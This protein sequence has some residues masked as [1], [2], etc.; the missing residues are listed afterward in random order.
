M[1]DI[2]GDRQVCKK[3]HLK[4]LLEPV[5]WAGHACKLWRQPH[6]TER[7]LQSKVLQ[8]S[9]D[10][11]IRQ[12]EEHLS[13]THGVA[14]IRRI[15]ACRNCAGQVAWVISI[16]SWPRPWTVLG[17]KLS[18]QPHNTQ[19]SNMARC[20]GSQDPRILV[21][22]GFHGPKGNLTPRRSDRPRIST[23]SIN[24]FI[25]CEYSRKPSYIFFK[26]SISSIFSFLSLSLFYLSFFFC[27]LNLFLIYFIRYFFHLNFQHYPKSLAYPPPPPLPYPLTTTF[28][29]W[30]SPVLGHN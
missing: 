30:R 5:P 7:L 16:L 10:Q 3:H 20:R 23:F 18:S 4:I 13:S 11:I 24:F 9:K 22:P 25:T 26:A 1:S 29:H 27:S 8:H 17:R 28:W 15:Q 2:F 6:N 12:E 21:P 19:S 14:G